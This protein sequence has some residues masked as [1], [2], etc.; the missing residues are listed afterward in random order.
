MVQ[1]SSNTFGES[2]QVPLIHSKSS[3]STEVLASTE[4][5]NDDY[6]RLEPQQT[7]E[8][9]SVIFAIKK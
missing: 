6:D 9:V 2:D 8:N 7:V 1:S 5:K 3:S 4:V